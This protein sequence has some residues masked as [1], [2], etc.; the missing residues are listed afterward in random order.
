MMVLLS[1]EDLLNTKRI[2]STIL[3]EL[4]LDGYML[5]YVVD[6]IKA[7]EAKGYD[8]YSINLEFIANIDENKFNNLSFPEKLQVEMQVRDLLERKFVGFHIS[9]NLRPVA[10][11]DLEDIIISFYWDSNL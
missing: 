6:C 5:G 2:S 8:K 7:S 10:S 1:V 3:E 4:E 11:E 9:S